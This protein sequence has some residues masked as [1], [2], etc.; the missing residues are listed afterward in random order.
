MNA[1]RA[2]AARDGRRA[3]TQPTDN[4]RCAPPT[5]PP[6]ATHRHRAHDA[7][8]LFV[9]PSCR[10]NATR[11]MPHE[12]M[13]PEPIDGRRTATQPTDDPAC[14]RAATHRHRAPDATP[15]ST[16]AA[17]FVPPELPHGLTSQCHPSQSTGDAPRRSP[18]TIRY[19]PPPA[20]PAATHHYHAPDATPTSTYASTKPTPRRGHARSLPS[21][22]A[23]LRTSRRPTLGHQTAEPTHWCTRLHPSP[24][25]APAQHPCTGARPRRSARRSSR[26]LRAPRP[27]GRDVCVLRVTPC[28]S[29][30]SVSQTSPRP[31]ANTS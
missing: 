15:T 7:T 4:P 1:S 25:P 14:A 26:V 5:S 10:M 27:S 24:H 31:G 17:L 16:R 8:R 19:A 13:P 30:D 23:A 28:D 22:A 11:R 12:P 2:H 9:P 18:P 20:P 3:A 29:C 6:A 21:T